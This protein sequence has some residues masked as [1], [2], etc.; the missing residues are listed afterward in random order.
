MITVL[1]VDEKNGVVV[2][3]ALEPEQVVKAMGVPILVT[4]EP[5]PD[6]VYGYTFKMPEA[7]LRVAGQVAVQEAE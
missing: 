4:I 6:P 5:Q 2:I 7:V 3:Q 1:D